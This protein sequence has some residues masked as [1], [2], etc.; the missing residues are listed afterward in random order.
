MKTLI[1]FINEK[2]EEK[3]SDYLRRRAAID[4]K[5]DHENGPELNKINDNEWERELNTLDKDFPKEAK[6]YHAERCSSVK[7]DVKKPNKVNSEELPAEYLKELAE[8]NDKYDHEFGDREKNR[9]ND[10][11]WDNAIA[12]LKRKYKIK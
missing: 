1:N 8:I 9:K 7:C 3:Y 6:R 10:E 11:A 2:Q 4:D 12:E 5:Y